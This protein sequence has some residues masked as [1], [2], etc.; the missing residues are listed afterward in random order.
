MSRYGDDAVNQGYRV[1]T[2]ID[3]RL[4]TAANRAVRIGLIEYDRRHGYRGALKQL[5]L[6]ERSAPAKLD[7]AL[8][9]IPEIGG[10]HA[11]LVVSVAPM[12]A[13]A[14]I[15]SIGFAQIEWDGLSWAHRRISDTRVGMRKTSC[16]AAMWSTW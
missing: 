15:R 11:A 8:G 4:Q 13:R 5:T 12:A 9:D 2:T 1:Y 16:S 6:D 3:G 10:L 14:Y 7:A